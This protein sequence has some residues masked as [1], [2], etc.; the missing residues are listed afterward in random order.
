MPTL[1]VEQ[2]HTR[3]LRQSVAFDLRVADGVLTLHAFSYGKPYTLDVRKLSFTEQPHGSSFPTKISVAIGAPSYVKRPRPHN[4]GQGVREF[5]MP[6]Q[7]PR[8]GAP[9]L[10]DVRL[11]AQPGFAVTDDGANLPF[12]DWSNRST[13]P[14]MVQMWWPGWSKD[15]A[16]LREA[17]RRFRG[18]NIYG[19]GGI[20]LGCAHWFYAYKADTPIHVREVLRD[21]GRVEE[22][23]PGTTISAGDDRAP[24]FFAFDPLRFLVDLPKVISV[25]SG[26]SSGSSSES[27]R[28]Q[29][30]CPALM[31]ADWQTDVTISRKAPPFLPR[32]TGPYPQFR[33]G[34]QR[35][36]V[37]WRFGYPRE[38][39]GLTTLQKARKWT[40]DGN[41]SNSFW[42]E[43]GNRG[44]SNF[45]RVHQ[46]Q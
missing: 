29:E 22:L 14:W 13:L 6:V 2:K 33:I 17:Q 3:H 18:R 30:A 43:F 28:S 11:R 16:A 8:P 35:S 5:S 4:T 46:M 34:M 20:V 31:L 19:Y 45:I 1:S 24:H 25:G 26:G 36:E 12:G 42:V 37:A 38:Y 23:W 9:G 15:D 40:Y 32:L 44:V 27:R 7:F 39:A 21:T 10:Y 41:P